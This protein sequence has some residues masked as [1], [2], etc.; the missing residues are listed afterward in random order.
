MCW[1]KALHLI[2]LV[3]V[4]EGDAECFEGGDELYGIEPDAPCQPVTGIDFYES[5]E[6]S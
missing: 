1:R 6:V 3:R 2:Y 4:L 5:L